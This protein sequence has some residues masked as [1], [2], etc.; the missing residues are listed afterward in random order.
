M[1][2]QFQKKSMKEILVNNKPI[3]AYPLP[4]ENS[5]SRILGDMI[6]LGE[7]KKAQQDWLYGSLFKKTKDVQQS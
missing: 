7:N 6:R 1:T 5:M 3:Y 2:L 4:K